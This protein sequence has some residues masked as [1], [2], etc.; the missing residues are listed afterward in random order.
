MRNVLLETVTD[1]LTISLG[2]KMFFFKNR[3]IYGIGK[4]IDCCDE[5]RIPILINYPGSLAFSPSGFE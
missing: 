1:Y 3:K 5:S 2:D 4:V